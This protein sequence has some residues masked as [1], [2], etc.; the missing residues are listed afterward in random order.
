[1]WDFRYF[2]VFLLVILGNVDFAWTYLRHLKA[3][4]CKYIFC[5]NNDSPEV[6][7]SSSES[8]TWEWLH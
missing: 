4:V 2:S 6:S 5:V 1:M 3:Y 8:R 7:N